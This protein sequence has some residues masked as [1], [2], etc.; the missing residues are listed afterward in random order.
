MSHVQAFVNCDVPGF[1]TLEWSPTGSVSWTALSSVGGWQSFK[2]YLGLLDTLL[3][4][5]GAWSVSYNATLDRVVFTPGG[6]AVD[7][8]FRLESQSMADLLGFDSVLV[9]NATGAVDAIVGDK[10]PAGVCPLVSLSFGDPVPVR[11]SELRAF[12]HRRSHAVASG[13]GTEYTLRLTA[14]YSDRLRIQAGPLACGKVRLGDW[15]ET[16]A[17]DA[18]NLDGFLDAFLIGQRRIT[19]TEG[20]VE[21]HLTSE[22]DALAPA[23]AHSPTEA[24]SDSVFGSLRR[25][26]SLNYY[27]LIEGLPIRYCEH[28]PPGLTDSTY[29][30]RAELVVDGAQQLTHKLDRFKGCAAASGLRL[31]IMDPTNAA[32]IFG[33]PARETDLTA[34]VE[35]SSG[36]PTSIAVTST[37]GW[38][39][40]GVAYLGTEALKYTGTT[41]TAFTGITRP[42]GPGYGYGFGGSFKFRTV[43]E[44]PI[45]WNGKTVRL[46]AQLLDPFG[47]AVDTVWDG[48]QTRQVY[49]GEVEN[50]P[51]Y[52]AG[53]W[54]L[55]TR[56]LIRRIATAKIG[57]S[58][59][60]KLSPTQDWSS[61][62]MADATEIGSKVDPAQILVYTAADAELSLH[63]TGLEAN[64]AY[65]GD[66][67]FFN[68]V[69][70]IS[71]TGLAGVA[72]TYGD[73]IKTLL[74]RVSEAVIPDYGTVD[75]IIN[76]ATMAE[77]I[78][79]GLYDEGP[80]ITIADD[81]RIL[82]HVLAAKNQALSDSMYLTA[83]IISQ[84][85]KAPYW[86]NETVTILDQINEPTNFSEWQSKTIDTGFTGKG[87]GAFTIRQG[88]GEAAIAGTFPASGFA[89]VEGDGSAFELLSYTG[90]SA[91]SATVLMLTGL[92]RTILGEA[93]NLFNPSGKVQAAD[94]IS[95]V[96]PGIV[97][98][99][100]I[101]SS[102]WGDRGTY[103][104]LGA[105]FGH[106]LPAADYVHHTGSQAALDAKFGPLISIAIGKPE[107]VESYLGG[108]FVAHE[109][110]LGWVR[111]GTKLL[112]GAPVVFPAGA[113]SEIAHTITDA[114]LAVDGAASIARIAPGPNVVHVKR[115]ST[116]GEDGGDSFTYRILE[117]VAA[118]GGQEG[119]YSLMG[120][121]PGDFVVLGAQ[122]ATKLANGALAEVAYR[123]K[124]AG[125]RD[126]LA[127]Q[128]VRINVTHAGLWD[129][130]ANAPGLNSLGRILESRRNLKTGECEIVVLVQGPSLLAALCPSAVVASSSGADLTLDDASAF[131]EGDA[132]K[133][134]DPGVA[135][136]PG[137]RRISA[138]DGNVIT[139][140][141]AFSV[142]D[143]ITIVTYASDDHASITDEQKAHTHPGDGS[144]WL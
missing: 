87:A 72:R 135:A 17:F 67:A 49:A 13:T 80:M 60:A 111:S 133:L 7:Y 69:I 8:F 118:R 2:D 33:R 99:R 29:T 45:A 74:F 51:G 1:K 106:A 64:A 105:G 22:F 115:E 18:D 23:A 78:K 134:Y 123:L 41:G 32:G 92:T 130:A 20:D 34:D 71:M 73:A 79:L 95:G 82:C 124:V 127:G 57:S 144:R 137:E 15:Y 43:A 103:D 142:N 113:K 125:N 42:F 102:G 5:L 94:V 12:R 116:F 77:E 58:A 35:Y 114:D 100:L 28:N 120:V 66:V 21:G 104:T 11:R 129:F 128:L 37:A 44:R 46:F 61:P 47:A 36:W 84:N 110:C 16:D 48:A 89:V 107:T 55:Q 38:P 39:S 112:I 97:A 30:V 91:I 54:V 9:S 85:D 93:A 136:S 76:S 86:F 53:I 68:Y 126:W 88:A 101:E 139:L 40:S 98:A 3:S 6:G 122:L 70:P 14:L 63:I 117:D 62:A 27:T 25:G 75:E 4:G 65:A 50:L 83:R 19:L 132:V 10:P 52:D 109:R 31:G 140:D 56:D 96:R 143:G 24:L 81:G 121:P 119:S 26:Y 131:A 138:V 141:S 59:S 108:V 90:T